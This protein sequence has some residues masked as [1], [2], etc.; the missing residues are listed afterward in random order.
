[1]GDDNHNHAGLRESFGGSTFIGAKELKYDQI[2]EAM[3]KGNI[4]CASGR[5]N[6]PQFKS[7]YVEDNMLKIEC[8]PV[9]SIIV[10]GYCRADRHT[11]HDDDSEGLTHDE[12]W[13]RES[14]VYFRVTIRDKFGNSAHT[15]TYFVKDYIDKK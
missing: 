13:L 3:E 6:P 1:M 12:F 14:D 2:I 4:Y 8:T 15:H 5:D 9:E 11:T 10:N 7:L